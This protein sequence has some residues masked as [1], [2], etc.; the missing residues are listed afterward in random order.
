MC[1]EDVLRWV[2]NILI[3]AFGLLMVFL[4]VTMITDYRPKDKEK[5]E[6][7]NNKCAAVPINNML[8]IT[9]YNIGYAGLDK[10]Q[11]FYM[12]GGKN[13]KSS[14]KKKTIENIVHTGHYLQK[15]D[16]CFYFLQE[17]DKK[18]T[19]SHYINQYDYLKKK[20][21]KHNHQFAYNYK[22]AWVPVPITKPHGHVDSGMATLSK[23]KVKESNRYALPGKETYLK[24]LMLLDRCAMESRVVIEHSRKELVLL[25]IHLSTFDKDGKLRKQQLEYLQKYLS[26]ENKKGNYVIVGGDW[27]H[28]LVE[29]NFK[30]EHKTGAY[31]VKLPKEFK[32]EGY[33]WAVDNKTPT[34]RETNRP[35]VEGKSYVDVIDG[36][37][38]SKN[39]QIVK[40]E[41]SNLKFEYSNHNPVTMQFKLK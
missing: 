2:R 41:T 26:E 11:D 28:K 17:V 36:Y 25:N 14:S 9:T 3:G 12:G 24:Q 18:S 10:N 38:V 29:T 16:S 30:S 27:N 39:I 4:L 13:S 6:V 31:V 23:Y 8:T 15:K 40:V 21:P 20:F 35:Y 5:I 1:M 32:P 22:V 19:R 7:E 37:L 34:L 33:N